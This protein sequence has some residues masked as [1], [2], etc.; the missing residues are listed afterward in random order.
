MKVF[1]EETR[2]KMSESAKKRCTDDWKKNKSDKTETKLDTDMVRFLYSNGATQTEIAAILSVSQ[3][4]IWRH[5]KNHGIQ[6]R[7][8]AKRD[9]TKERNHMWKGECAKYQAFHLRINNEK[10]SAKSHGCSVCGANDESL[11]YDWA[12]LTGKYY[13]TSDYAPMCRSCHRKYDKERRGD[14]KCQLEN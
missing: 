1:S 2:I 12:N 7:V 6:A 4:V 8:A 3:K 14:L 9:Q 13:D 10:G 5:M 11:W